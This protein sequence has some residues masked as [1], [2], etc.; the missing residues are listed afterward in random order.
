MFRKP[1]ALTHTYTKKRYTAVQ[2]R[3]VSGHVVSH[4]NTQAA[5]CVDCWT[6]AEAKE[7]RKSVSPSGEFHHI[8]T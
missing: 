8:S 7:K 5:K 1:L 3:T 6:A 2:T 4:A